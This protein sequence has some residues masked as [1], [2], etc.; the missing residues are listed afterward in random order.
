MEISHVIR[1]E[2][3]VTS[4]P[5]HVL[6]YDAFGWEHPV[7]A[8]LPLILAPNKKKLGKRDGDKYGIPVFPIDWDYIDSDGNDISISGFREAGIEPDALVNFLSLLGWNPGGDVEHMSMDEM[9]NLF[10]TERIN[11]AGAMFDIKKLN[12][13]NSHYLRNRDTD[14]IIDKMNIPADHGLSDDKIDMIAS[15]ATERATYAYELDGIVDYIYNTPVLEEDIKMKNVEDFVRVMNVFAA[16][17]FMD[18]FE[19]SEW[20]PKNIRYE[21][22]HISANMSIKVGKIMP[23]LRTALCGGASGPQLPDVMY[24]IGPKETKLRIDT[25]L[26]KIKELA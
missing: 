15:M 11:Q 18:D 23:M 19:E 21:L 5:L 20:I 2:E 26:N 10:D 8:H 3:W 1:G 17:D 13:F 7:Y 9:I 6:M 16:D 12:S 24:V 25:L 4:T 14:W 22:E